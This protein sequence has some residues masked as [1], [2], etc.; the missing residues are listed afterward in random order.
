MSQ[1][2]AQEFFPAP[3]PFDGSIAPFDF[4]DTRLFAIV[5][6]RVGASVG[7]IDI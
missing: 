6:Y 3:Y 5:S 2:T 7:R 4:Y 1:K